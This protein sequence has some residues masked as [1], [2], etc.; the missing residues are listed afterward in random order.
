MLK[1]QLTL[2]S[3][4]YNTHHFYATSAVLP[5]DVPG[6]I[7]ML[8]ASGPR[9]TGMNVGTD[10]SVAGPCFLTVSSDSIKA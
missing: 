4:S 8:P 1:F 2:L 6:S 10:I 3:C 5:S 7:D 9:D